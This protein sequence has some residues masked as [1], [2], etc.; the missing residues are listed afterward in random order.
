MSFQRLAL[1]T[2]SLL[3]RARPVP[4]HDGQESPT[5]HHETSWARE[6][7]ATKKGNLRRRTLALASRAWRKTALCRRRDVLMPYSPAGISRTARRRALA[8][9]RSLSREPRFVGKTWALRR[10]KASRINPL[11]SSGAE[12]KRCAATGCACGRWAQRG[13]KKNLKAMRPLQV[14]LARPLQELA[15]PLQKLA[16]QLQ[17]MA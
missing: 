10:G 4:C 11:W 5:H 3:P 16:K 14:E 8:Q 15:R 2:F 6:A 12:R 17:E 9:E 7:S 1:E 13:W